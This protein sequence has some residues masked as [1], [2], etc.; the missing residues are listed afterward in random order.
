MATQNKM[1]ITLKIAIGSATQIAMFVA[2]VLVLVSLLFQKSMSLVFSGFERHML[3][4]FP[5]GTSNPF[6]T[7]AWTP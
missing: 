2:P 3:S 1:D 7:T 6:P 5:K 4:Y